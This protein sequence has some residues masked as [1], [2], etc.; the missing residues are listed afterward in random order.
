MLML[1]VA[2]TPR[3]PVQFHAAWRA[4]MKPIVEDL[5]IADW[6]DTSEK[7]FYHRNTVYQEFL[8][9][10]RVQYHVSFLGVKV[11]TPTFRGIY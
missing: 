9:E 8:R 1:L 10:V 5:G 3:T 2:T 11:E 7:N 4:S 6:S